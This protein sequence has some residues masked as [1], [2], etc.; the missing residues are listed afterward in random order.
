MVKTKKNK[1]KSGV[2][3]I[4][5]RPNV[6]KSTLLNTI[7]GEKI[8]IVS[9]V[10]QTTRNQIKGIY[11]DERGQIVFIDTPGLQLGKDTLDRYMNNSSSDTID[12]VDCLIYLVDTS[13]RIGEEEDFIANKVKTTKAPVILGLNK[14]DIKKNNLPEYIAF[15]ERV[16]GM[17]V[18]DMKKFA[19]IAL[20]GEKDI[21]TDQLLDLIFDFLPEGEALYPPDIITD[22]PQKMAMA[23]IIREK[24]LNIMREEVPHSI[25]VIIEDIYPLRRKVVGVKA[26]VFVERETQKEIVIGSKGLNLKQV[27]TL[28]R[29]ELEDL[30]EKKVFLELLVKTE[31]G[32]RDNVP[33]LQELGYIT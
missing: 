3:S 31:K 12:D 10:P 6:G 2:V 9:K 4:V 25:G 27:G 14:V 28:A 15:W 13:R 23:D 21:N 8:A 30:L 20:S 17:P 26:M 32:W 24:L 33:L 11:N 16:K 19:L 18:A 5:G 22:V 7:V 1:F 29:K